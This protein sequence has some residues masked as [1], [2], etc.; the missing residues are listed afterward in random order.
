MQWVPSHVGVARNEKADYLAKMGTTCPLPAITPT[1][2]S[3]KGFIEA[4][5]RSKVKNDHWNAAQ[6]QLWEPLV[7]CSLPRDLPRATSVA[8]FRLMMGHD[9]LQ[10][11]LH[12]IHVVPDDQCTL[13][14]NGRMDAGHLYTCAALADVWAANQPHL[15]NPLSTTLIGSRYDDA[16]NTEQHKE[17]A[18]VACTTSGNW[19]PTEGCCRCVLFACVFMQMAQKKQAYVLEGNPEQGNAE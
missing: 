6:G 8:T 12:K 16:F 10:A 7:K 1:L 14:S 17:S 19:L 11:H 9:Y 13:Y 4:A 3:A 15:T 5:V 2:S 18:A